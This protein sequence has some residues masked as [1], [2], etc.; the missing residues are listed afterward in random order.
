MVSLK[1]REKAPREVCDFSWNSVSSFS[2]SW[3]GFS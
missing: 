1:R 2:S 3:C